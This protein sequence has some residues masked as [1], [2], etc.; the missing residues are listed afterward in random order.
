MTKINKNYSSTIISPT[1]IGIKKMNIIGLV[2]DQFRIIIQVKDN[3]IGGLSKVVDKM[4]LNILS[5]C[6]INVSF[7]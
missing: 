5:S 7:H 3:K 1:F 2:N 6:I 4:S